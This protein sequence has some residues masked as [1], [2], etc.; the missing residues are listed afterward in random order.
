MHSSTLYLVIMLFSL[1]FDGYR[2]KILIDTR[3]NPKSSQI[4]TQENQNTT[5]LKIKYKKTNFVG[6][7][8][9]PIVHYK[10]DF[11]KNNPVKQL[12][13]GIDPRWCIICDII[14]VQS[15]PLNLNFVLQR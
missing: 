12:A 8:P 1:L 5:K 10:V 7:I 2:D 13:I 6:K 3:V 14:E 11:L 15:N 9:S 4:P